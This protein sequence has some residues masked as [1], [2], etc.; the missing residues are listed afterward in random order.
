MKKVLI[1][2]D[3]PAILQM[4]KRLVEK[5]GYLVELA[6]DGEDGM[7]L[8]E[9]GSFDLVITDIIMPKKEGIEIITAIRKNHPKTK[10]IAMSGGGKFA[11]EGYLKS[12]NMLGA[13][14]IFKKPFNHR[15]M[16]DAIKELLG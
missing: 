11:P 14:R 12:A 8:F 6:S 9:E 4:M 3:E 13:T 10:I 16:I 1:I 5:A 15:E 7:I 2:D